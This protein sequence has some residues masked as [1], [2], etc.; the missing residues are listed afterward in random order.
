MGTAFFST[1]TE[2]ECPTCNG[3]GYEITNPCY[4]CRG[5]SVTNII[6]NIKVDIP[7]S[8]DNGD[9]MRVSQK[10]DFYGN[11]GF[12]DLIIK[13]SVEKTDNFEKL[14]MDL[15]YYKEFSALDILFGGKFTVPHPDGEI[16][17]NHPEN[18]NTEKPLRVK[19]KGYVNRSGVGN[20]Y[21]KLIVKDNT[22]LS[23]QQKENI[24]KLVQST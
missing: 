7:K 11:L 16:L 15:V 10:G 6:E 8:V 22:T 18:F 5:N 4:S 20:L 23:E 24:R 2:V 21:V 1:V 14:D 17:I 9:F 13:I 19:G 12:G 3:G